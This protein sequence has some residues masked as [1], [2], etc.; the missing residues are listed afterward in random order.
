[1]KLSPEQELTQLKTRFYSLANGILAMGYVVGA[2][3]V[4]AQLYQML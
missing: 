3:W 1:M 2:V 4:I